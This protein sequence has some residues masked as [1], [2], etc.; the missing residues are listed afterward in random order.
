MRSTCAAEQRDELLRRFSRLGVHMVRK[1][2]GLLGF[3]LESLWGLR[4]STH[5]ETQEVIG[6]VD[7]GAPPE[8]G[9]FILVFSFC[10]R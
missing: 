8:I 10:G 3:A 1:W 6:L 7:V 4:W 9:R 2:G 5:V